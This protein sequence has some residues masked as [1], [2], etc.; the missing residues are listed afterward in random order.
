MTPN[1][2]LVEDELAIQELLAY[3]ITQCGYRATQAFDAASAWTHISHA[4]PDLILLD[5]MLPGSSGVELARRLRAEQRTRN[6]PIIMLTARTDERDK[7]MGLESGAD[8]PRIFPTRR[9][10]SRSARSASTR[11]STRSGSASSSGGRHGSS[12]AP[13]RRSSWCAP[14]PGGRRRWRS[15]WKLASGRSTSSARSTRAR[16]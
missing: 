9:S 5:W 7:I 1:I 10:A 14:A 3:N 2:L 8:R 11:R 4:L 15:C 16:A 12:T 13:R 6:I